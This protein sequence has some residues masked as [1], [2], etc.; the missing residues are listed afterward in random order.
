MTQPRIDQTDAGRVG[1]WRLLMSNPV[2]VVSST[3]LVVVFA[4]AIGATWIAPHGIND[5]DVPSALR[6]PSAAPVS[7]THLTLPTILLV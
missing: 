2:T 4:V 6:G 3:I 7:Y 1:S 5:V